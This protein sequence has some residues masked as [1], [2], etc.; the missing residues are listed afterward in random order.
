MTG[1]Y[2]ARHKDAH[3]RALRVAYKQTGNA[4]G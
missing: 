1:R 4:G 2:I 3:T